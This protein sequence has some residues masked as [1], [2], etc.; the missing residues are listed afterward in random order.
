MVKKVGVLLIFAMLLSVFVVG[1]GGKTSAPAPSDEGKTYTIKL[2]HVVAETQS[3][4]I[5]ARDVF[6]KYVEEKSAGKIKV[7]IYP[8]GQLGSDRQ[9]IEAVQLGTIQMTIPAAAV[10]SGFEKKFQVFDLPYLFKSKEAAYKALDGELGKKLNQEVEKIGLINMAYGENGFRHISNNKKP[11]EKP[12]DLKGL[13]IRTMENPVHLATF[14]ALGANPTPIAFGELY[15]ALQQGTVDAQENPI[16]L[17]FTSKFYE[18]Q[19]YYSLD[20]HVYAATVVLI[21]KDFFSQL[22][23]D[24]QKVVREGAEKYRDE[25][26][27]ISSQQDVEML[28]ALKKSG[29]MVNELT[30]AQKQ[31]FIDATL[32]VY[33][34]FKDVLGSDLIELA[35][36]A[37]K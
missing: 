1:C 26:R 5:A 23:A 21:N 8:N 6:K 16:P 35:K 25:Q 30:D 13:K 32:P 31:V 17:V 2:A 22:P 12:A 24:L 4:H 37:N 20:G 19:K 15:T 34:Q 18:V 7:E 14:K 10:L 36:S 28:D 33:D 29:M 9:A 11:I 27:K 3:T